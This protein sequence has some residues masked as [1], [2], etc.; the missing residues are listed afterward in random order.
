[1]RR[2]VVAAV[3]AALLMPGTAGASAGPTIEA[4]PNP[5]HVGE[6][7]VHKTTLPEQGILHLWVSARG[8]RQPGDGTLPPGSWTWECCPMQTAGT[9]AWHFRSERPAA[10]GR[11]RFGALAR[12]TGTFLSTVSVNALSDGVWIRVT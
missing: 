8:F 5:A 10:A 7:V 11:Y 4:S 1:M 3:V 9:P 6:K 12:T 2:F